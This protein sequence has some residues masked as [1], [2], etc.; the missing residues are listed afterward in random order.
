MDFL[1]CAAG[2]YSG[3]MRNLPLIIACVALAAG[4]PAIQ[5]KDHGKGK[6]QSRVEVVVFQ[7]ASRQ[8]IIDFFHTPPSGLPPGLAKRG[9]DLPPGLEKQLRRNG[10][11][12]PGLE[13]KLVAFPV[14]LE[15][16]LPP[17]PAGYR[18]GMIGGR[19][20]IFD[21]GRLILDVFV[22]F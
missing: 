5:G 11:L 10:R 15:R 8:I 20:V 12:P 6:G 7:P 17:L 2:V 18:R 21:P 16:R 13:K 14:E 9:G 19:A 22:A 3:I 4:T 1:A